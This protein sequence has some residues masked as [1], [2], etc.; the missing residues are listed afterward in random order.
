M[1]Y[2]ISFLIHSFTG[3]MSTW[4]FT[5]TS[6]SEDGLPM[7]CWNPRNRILIFACIMTFEI[8]G[9][10][11]CLPLSR[12]SQISTQEAGY[13][14]NVS[15]NMHPIS[16][17]MRRWTPKSRGWSLNS[18]STWEDSM[19]CLPLSPSVKWKIFIIICSITGRIKCGKYMQSA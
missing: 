3:L 12:L 19:N 16:A 9:N 18:D 8:Y 11:S 15:G 14:A 6:H 1:Q 2:L 17:A 4:K 10:Q 13:R 5:F 7:N